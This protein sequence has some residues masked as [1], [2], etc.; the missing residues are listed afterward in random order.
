[1]YERFRHHYH[2]LH[3]ISG[4]N[5]VAIF[6]EHGDDTKLEEAVD[7]ALRKPPTAADDTSQV[8]DHVRDVKRAATESATVHWGRVL[9]GV[10]IAAGLILGAI[11]LAFLADAWAADQAA[12]AAANENYEAPSSQLPAIATALMA[13]ATAWSG[14]IVGALFAEAKS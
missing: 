9:V 3:P 2:G 5:P 12:K 11:V 8:R 7:R 13:L 6:V 1:L 4:G 14:A 10:A